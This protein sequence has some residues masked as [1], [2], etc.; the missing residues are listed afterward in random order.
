M[1]NEPIDYNMLWGEDEPVSPQAS[2]NFFDEG[3][4]IRHSF[5]RT[6]S[7]EKAA[8]KDRLEI[9]KAKTTSIFKEI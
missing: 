4:V 7:F 3:Q 8:M 6:E 9:I 2:R 1:C 5:D